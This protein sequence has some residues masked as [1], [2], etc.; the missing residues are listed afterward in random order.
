[1]IICLI[2]KLKYLIIFNLKTFLHVQPT[3][4]WPLETLF[5]PLRKKT[6]V[7]VFFYLQVL[8]LPFANLQTS[9]PQSEV[10]PLRTVTMAS[11]PRSTMAKDALRPREKPRLGGRS[12]C[13]GT[14][15][16]RSSGLQPGDVVVSNR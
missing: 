13:S 10:V 7:Y 16:S 15:P 11:V 12:I 9:R 8:M 2:L 6:S 14:T 5:N 3:V 4:K 1:M